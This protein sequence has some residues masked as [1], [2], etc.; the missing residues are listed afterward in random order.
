MPAGILISA[1]SFSDT[2]VSPCEVGQ[3]HQLV[4]L[5]S[6]AT[7]L[8]SCSRSCLTFVMLITAYWCQSLVPCLHSA[9]AWALAANQEADGPI[10][11]TQMLSV[12]SL[13]YSILSKA[14]RQRDCH[15]SEA[16]TIS[17]GSI[18]ACFWAFLSLHH[19][20]QVSALCWCHS[21]L[22]QDQEDVVRKVVANLAPG[23][24]KSHLCDGFLSHLVWILKSEIAWNKAC[25]TV[26][27]EMCFLKQGLL[28]HLKKRPI[29]FNL[30]L[31][32]FFSSVLK[33]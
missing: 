12:S 6:W 30:F 11:R 29:N 24:D 19:I 1:D 7:A 28:T 27:P 14:V 8:R 15:Y 9:L 26:M 23:Y 16:V 5:R 17:I 22:C 18:W 20:A 31:G 33:F 10:S 21:S 4:S 2:D 25:H 3:D 13:H 32:I